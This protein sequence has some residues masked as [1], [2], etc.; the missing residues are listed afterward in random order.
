MKTGLFWGMLGAGGG[1]ESGNVGNEGSGSISGQNGP[2]EKAA[3]QQSRVRVR[4]RAG[5]CRKNLPAGTV[6]R[7][8]LRLE[9]FR[10]ARKGKSQRVGV[11]DNPPKDSFPPPPLFS[12]YCC[13][14]TFLFNMGGSQR[15]P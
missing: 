13:Y 7:E 8:A 1:K 6:R 11:G 4:T 10:C 14:I 12:F 15:T 9:W 2:R 5:V 3:A